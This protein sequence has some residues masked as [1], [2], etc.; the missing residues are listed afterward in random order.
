ME[1]PGA[2]FNPPILSYGSPGFLSYISGAGGVTDKANL[3]RAYIQYSNGISR[4][5]RHFLFFRNY[6]R[7]MPGSKII[8]PERLEGERRGLSIVEISALTGSFTALISLI[9]VLRK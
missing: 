3:R 2:G 4:K 7:V 6:P 9:A 1:V 5:I 8:V